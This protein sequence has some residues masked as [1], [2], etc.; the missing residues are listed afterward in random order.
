MDQL[1][2]GTKPPKVR[3]TRD[4]ALKVIKAKWPQ[5]PLDPTAPRES[6]RA[7]GDAGESNPDF[8]NLLATV[9]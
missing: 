3:S 1:K 4:L 6:V 8:D 5:V 7:R 9:G 2:P